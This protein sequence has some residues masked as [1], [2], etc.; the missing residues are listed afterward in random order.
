[1]QATRPRATAAEA[2]PELDLLRATALLAVVFIHAASWVAGGDA[3][4][5]QGPYAAAIALARFSVP[6]FVLA[7]GL[8]LRHAYG[9]PDDARA[10]LRRRALRT[11]APWL[12]WVPVYA[13]VDMVY[14]KVAPNPHD[15]AVWLA[16]GP[17]HLYF[18][19]LVAQLSLLFPI[20][21]SGR[22]RLAALAAAALAMQLALGV[23]R[24]YGPL[25]TGPLTWPVTYLPQLEAP[26]WIGWFL[27][28]CALAADYERFRALSRLWPAA[29]AVAVLGGA[30]VLAEAFVV[31]PDAARQGTAA[32]L[33]PSRLP[34]TLAIAL[35]LLWAGRELAPHA[36][37]LWA[38]VRAISRRSLGI[39]VI[40]VAVIEVLAHTAL[41]GLPPAPRLAVLMGG[42]L[43]IAYG[44][45]SALAR[46]GAGA[47][48]LGETRRIRW[49]PSAAG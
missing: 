20:L 5:Q 40:H 24:T 48:A 26:F 47:L 49:R 41:L 31:P 8:A 28:G 43:L 45:T 44:L 16:Y 38:V 15:I 27:L 39:Y 7:S 17:G 36:G 21:P 42:S 25:P 3:P 12:A 35:L 4:V 22:A 18:L 30:A 6:A 46:T 14:G 37:W 10:F 19:V 13:A 9:R 34:A 33:W 32:F 2:L 1:M 23:A 11:L 29:L